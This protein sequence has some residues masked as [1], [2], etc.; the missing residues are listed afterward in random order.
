MEIK[1]YH[2]K[3]LKENLIDMGLQL[4]NEVG[5]DNFSMRKVANLCK[6]SHNAPYRHF[7]DKEDMIRAILEKAVNDFQDILLSAVNEH[8]GNPLEKIRS[9][10]INYVSF[11]AEKPEYLHLFFNSDFKGK[12]YIKD[13]QISYDEAYLFEIFMDCITEYYNSIGKKQ[14]PGPIIALEFWSTIH[15]LATFIANKKIVF[16]D[17]YKIYVSEV[18]DRLLLKLDGE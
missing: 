6:V 8:Q 13:R 1:K 4:L 9:I 7:A 12:V 17:N 2:N 14:D 15:G 3:D 18:I 10:G 11:F 16:L 5:Y